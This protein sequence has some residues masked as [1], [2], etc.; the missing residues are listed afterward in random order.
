ML[1]CNTSLYYIK[2]DHITLVAYM[3]EVIVQFPS[4]VS[5]EQNISLRDPISI[6]ELIEA[7]VN[8]YSLIQ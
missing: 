5:E 4:F 7:E 1:E 6:Y 2:D 8:I 3:L